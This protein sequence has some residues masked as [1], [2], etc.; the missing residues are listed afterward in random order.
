MFTVGI[1]HK[2]HLV[3][4]WSRGKLREKHNFN[5][6]SK[7]SNPE[8]SQA[9]PNKQQNKILLFAAVVVLSAN[10]KLHM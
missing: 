7:G 9:V 10:N 6:I 4:K 2:V 3:L 8:D 1:P 5:F